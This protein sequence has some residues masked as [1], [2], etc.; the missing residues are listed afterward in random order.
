ML[1]AKF[2]SKDGWGSD[3]FAPELTCNTIDQRKKAAKTMKLG[4]IRNN[5]KLPLGFRGER[6][7]FDRT[8]LNADGLI[9]W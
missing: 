3:D 7:L 1:S 5:T 4:D 8:L 2:R 9:N 6:W